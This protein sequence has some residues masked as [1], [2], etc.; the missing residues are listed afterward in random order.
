MNVSEWIMHFVS[1]ALLKNDTQRLQLFRLLQQG[2]M[3]R[4]TMPE[5]AYDMY[6]QGRK[7]AEDLSESCWILLFAQRMAHI[8]IYELEN[9]DRALDLVVRDYVL[10]TQDSYKHCP[11]NSEIRLNL[12]ETYLYYDPVGYA[13][14]ITETI[15]YLLETEQDEPHTIT[16][17]WDFRAQL[18]LKLD[19]LDLAIEYALHSITNDMWDY[20]TLTR[21][22]W[23]RGDYAQA[24]QMSLEREALLNQSYSN[25]YTL[26]DAQAWTAAMMMKIDKSDASAHARFTRASFTISKINFVPNSTLYDALAEY[27]EASG[28]PELA[29]KVR[30]EQLRIQKAIVGAE[31]LIMPRI[32]RARLLGRIGKIEEMN[33]QLTQIES[34]LPRLKKPVP[35]IVKLNLIKKGEY[36]DVVWKLLD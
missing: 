31:E 35:Y 3:M 15:D 19:Q 2:D 32:R 22:Y 23:E 10:S 18:A 16:Q 14:K 34:Y 29:L 12:V 4:A 26:A 27:H 5:L 9:L 11:V 28:N 36:S 33:V 7:L 17:L 8:C 21:I 6:A 24:L 13:E 1:Q 20:L 25:S 30:D